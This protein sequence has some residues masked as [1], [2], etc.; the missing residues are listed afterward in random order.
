MLPVGRPSSIDPSS[1]SQA[2]QRRGKINKRSKSKMKIKIKKMIKSK[3]KIKSKIASAG[4]P[5]SC[6]NGS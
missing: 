1:T 5:K 6:A 3:I 2:H 4:I